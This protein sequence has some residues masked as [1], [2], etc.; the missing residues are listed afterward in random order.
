MWMKKKNF[1]NWHKIIVLVII[2]VLNSQRQELIKRRE[3]MD[4]AKHEY[5][6]N[7][8]DQRKETCSKA[9]AKFNEQSEEVRKKKSLNVL[10]LKWKLKK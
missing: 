9:I 6:N 5:A 10:S 4:F 7:P 1:F 3:E 8:T 2:L